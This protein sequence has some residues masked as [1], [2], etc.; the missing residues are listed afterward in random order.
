MA[1]PYRYLSKGIYRGIRVDQV[2][3]RGFCLLVFF[4]S[5]RGIIANW[6]S[7]YIKILQTTRTRASVLTPV[8]AVPMGKKLVS[9]IRE[10]RCSKTKPALR[11][12]AALRA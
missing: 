5:P 10:P 4:V 6:L 9:C 7:L 8:L 11:L 3:L 12:L 2:T 1:F